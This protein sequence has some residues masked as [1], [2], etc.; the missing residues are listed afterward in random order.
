MGSSLLRE[1][2]E[3]ADFSS[4]LRSISREPVPYFTQ[5]TAQKSLTQPTALL[6]TEDIAQR[7]EIASRHVYATGL[8][9]IPSLGLDSVCPQPEDESSLPE[10][11]F[12]SSADILSLTDV[13]PLFCLDYD[14]SDGDRI[15]Q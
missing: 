14:D 5:F 8:K 15:K 7:S 3:D 1:L 13:P 10:V 9:D 11:H 6:N 12:A 2:L 4:A